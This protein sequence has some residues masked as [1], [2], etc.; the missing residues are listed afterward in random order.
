MTAHGTLPRRYDTEAEY[1]RRKPAP[2][3]RNRTAARERATAE[4]IDAAN[5]SRHREIRTVR[6]PGGKAYALGAYAGTGIAHPYVP[7]GGSSTSCQLCFGW[8]SDYRH[9]STVWAVDRG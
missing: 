2:A 7:D 8:S 4:A 1:R 5:R 9:T 6:L 3:R